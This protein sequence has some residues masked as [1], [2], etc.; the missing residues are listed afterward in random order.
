MLEKLQ[1]GGQSI[2]IKI[3]LGLIIISFALAGIGTYIAAPSANYAAKV[4]GETISQAELE[5]AYQN[6]R[7]LMERQ[8]GDAFSA[9]A[10]N[11]EYMAQVKRGVLQQLVEQRLIVQ[12][13]KALGLTISD[14]QIKQEIMQM[15]AFQKDGKFDNAI[16]RSILSN[17]GL[18]PEYFS[19][20][21][22]QDLMTQQL[23]VAL[24]DSEFTVPAEV[25][26]LSALY[27]QTRSFSY[28]SVPAS[29]FTS[30]ISITDKDLQSYFESHKSQFRSDESVDINY[31]LVDA[32]QLAK[33]IKV[34]DEQARN[35]LQEHAD[36]YEQP[37]QR[38]VA[39]ILITVKN[40]QDQQAKAKA[41][42]ILKQLQAGA[43]FA[44]LAEADSDDKL[45]AKKGGELDWFQKGVMPAEF[46][47]A[48]FALAK[49]GD[50]SGVIKTKYGYH[51]IELLGVREAKLADFAAV[52]DQLV[53]QVQ[54]EQAMTQFYDL[55]QKLS[56]LS[57]EMP[58]SLDEVAK[59]MGV[60]VIHAKGVTRA[61]LPSEIQNSQVAQQIFS[62]T[63]IEQQQNSSVINLSPEQALVVRV[64]AHKAA[65]VKP[66]ADVK[67]QV[68]KSVEIQK[69]REASKAYAKQLLKVANDPE[70]FAK[71][72]AD[73]DLKIE[74]VTDFSRNSQS[75][76]NSLVL[77]KVFS[78]P[79][80]QKGK[81]EV[82]LID[83]AATE[84]Y[85]VRLTHIGQPD[86]PANLQQQIASQLKNQ[87]TNQSYQML[88]NYLRSKAD[89]SY[90]G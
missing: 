26:R 24:F 1:E 50:L 34:T 80:P 37:E 16:F 68:Q 3:I 79:H 69:S 15:P 41:E 63:A 7:Q 60:K 17:A 28:V 55:S 70:Q 75:D 74:S 62:Q 52:K 56:N 32:Q 30:G 66:F 11:S 9:L 23:R 86:V 33:T 83:V 65:A 2:V 8:S 85:V 51:I 46:D 48:A 10:N 18:T 78:M 81:D 59:Q 39:H 12:E 19:Q 90:H 13:S 89:I 47:K 49:S 25:N 4:N 21:T 20:L 22:R 38:H 27:N 43:N 45:T 36:H 82:Q 35:Y 29:K 6:Q 77:Q 84:P 87:L 14:Q 71:L 53:Q 54:Q 67:S 73:K 64:V 5:Q 42:A 40:G 58:D 72:V 76:I 61:H 88:L 31:I 44:K 57:Y